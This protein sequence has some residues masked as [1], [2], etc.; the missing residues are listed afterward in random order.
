[1]V[2][3]TLGSP[4]VSNVDNLALPSGGKIG[5]YDVLSVLGQGGFGITYRARDQQ[6]GREVAIKE[7]LPALLAYRHDGVAILPRSSKAVD[8]FTWGRER[9]VAEGRTLATLQ[10]APAIV[11][12]FDFI[13]GNGTAYIVM[14]LLQGETL[15]ATLQRQGKLDAAAI[16]RILWPLLDGLEQVHATGFLHRDIKPANILINGAGQPTLIDFGASRA[17]FAGRT[18]AMTAIFTPGYAAAEQFTST[19]QGAATDIYGLSATLYHAITGQP[20]P[21]AIE[22]MLDDDYQ[23]LMNLSTAGLAP[24]LLNAIDRGLA[25]RMTD[26]PQTIGAWRAVLGERIAATGMTPLISPITVAA[27]SVTP[28]GVLTSLQWKVLAD[29]VRRGECTPF[30]GTGVCLPT[31][32]TDIELASDLARTFDY[33]LPDHEDLA[34]VVQY[35]ALNARDATFPK[36]E[37]LDRIRARGRPDFTGDEPHHIL[38]KFPLPVY[39][40]TNY[41]DFMVSAL[42]MEKKE[43]H[44]D[45]CRWKADLAVYP[46][47]LQESNY[48]PTA[49]NPIVY[50]LHGCDMAADSLVATE[51]DYLE[52]IYNVARSGSMP[53]TVDRGWEILPPAILKAIS[54]NCLLFLGYRL[55]DWHFRIIF[56][57]LVLSLRR[58][59]TRL[60]VAVQL[61]P[62]P[63]ASYPEAAQKYLNA[64]FQDMFDVVIYWGTAQQFISDLRRHVES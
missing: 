41:D 31:L 57:W 51:D 1:M 38:A 55:T 46:T 45:F 6:L 21:S 18:A 53:K 26:R 61:S 9:F 24:S 34:H 16:D 13:E 49:D 17:A 60:K 58:T 7:Y 11:K 22:R 2:D 29:S 14:E 48:R 54:T 50:H 12:V 28:A 64:Y 33:P 62:A 43:C 27:T 52:F 10:N 36:Q 5:R 63:G 30:L 42:A 40:T 23:P 19:R 4:S 25:V 47:A 56:R 20:P 35:M 44:R 39:L 59:Q 8:D 37:I 3:A 32:T 15:D